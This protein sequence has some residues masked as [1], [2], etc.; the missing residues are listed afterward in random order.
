[1]SR[2]YTYFVTSA[3]GGATQGALRCRL[4]RGSEREYLVCLKKS[5]IDVYSLEKVG[6]SDAEGDER[7]EAPT[8]TATIEAHTNLLTFIEFRPPGADQSHLLA[9]T[10]NM[11]LLLLTFDA[12]A[13]K[14]ASRPLVSLQEIGAQE[15]ESDV[16]LRIDPG[17][18]FILFH[19]QKKTLK[20]VV[21][22]RE[23][24]FNIGHVITM[25][26]GESTF[27][28]VAFLDV[29][30]REVSGPAAARRADVGANM[31]ASR[32]AAASE[33]FTE[34]SR[35]KMRKSVLESKMLLIAAHR[36]GASAADDGEG[37][38]F[39]YCGVQL[40]FEIEHC[41]GDRRFT[42]YGCSPLFGESVP[43]AERFTR[44]VPLKLNAGPRCSDGALLLGSQAIGFVSF[45]DPRN[46]KLFHMDISVGEITS[47]C[48][49]EENRRYLVGDDTGALYLLDLV[50]SRTP[51]NSALKR[52]VE[53]T[54][55]SLPASKIA[56][57][58][59]CNSIVDVFAT[60]VGVYSPPSALVMIAPDLV[61]IAAVVG[62]CRTVRITGMHHGDGHASH[63]LMSA[64]ECD[65]AMRSVESRD[66]AD[67]KHRR[68]ESSEN[69]R[70][71]NLGPILDF[72][73]G[74]QR[75]QVAA[76]ILACCGYGAEGRVCS[77]TLGVGID[78]FASHTLEGVRRIFAVST[79]NGK[80]AITEVVMCCVFFN[81]TRFYK[82]ALP[83]TGHRRTS[84][85]TVI[86]PVDQPR[87]VVAPVSADSIG[88]TTNARTVLFG[89]YG[90]NR[91]VQVTSLG[92]SVVS[93]NGNDFPPQYF[94]VSDICSCAGV[95]ANPDAAAVA[96]VDAHWCDGGIFL[97]L[98]TH[99]ALVLSI[100]G[101]MRVPRWRQLSKQTSATAYV[102]GSEFKT[103]RPSGL[104]ALATWEDTEV[105]LLRDET[106]ETLHRTKV[107]C[108]YGV[109]ITALRFGIIEDK[110]FLFAALSD[111][112]LVVHKLTFGKTVGDNKSSFSS[113]CVGMTL[114]NIIKISED[115]IGLATLVVTPG[116]Q[117]GRFCRLAAS[118]IVTTGANPML[119]YANKGK[120]EYVPV[121][122]P[123]IATICSIDSGRQVGHVVP[124]LYTCNR[125][126][127]CIG[128]LDSTSQLHVETICSGRSFD[129]ICYHS[130]SDLVV[131]GCVGEL[132]ADS[133]SSISR[134]SAVQAHRSP[135]RDSEG[136]V[137][138]DGTAFRCIDVSSMIPLPGIC[139]LEPCAKFICLKTKEVVHTLKIP[140]RHVVSGVTTVAFDGHRTMIAI[141]T[142]R[143]SD[144]DEVPREGHI[145]L[146]DVVSSGP[147]SWNIVFL[148]TV[149]ALSA[150]IVEMTACSNALVVALND[151]V[152][153]MTLR[154]EDRPSVSQS[155]A[156]TAK[157]HKLEA[158]HASD[159][160]YG[161][162]ELVERAEYKSCTYVVSLD[163]YKDVIVVGD[164]MNSARMLRWRGNELRE[165][166]KD[167]NSVYCTAV[168]AIDKT[169]CVVSDSSGNFHVLGKPGS[170]TNDLEAMRVEDAGLFHHG[171]NINR[172]R[173][174]P[175][176]ENTVPKVESA[177]GRDMPTFCTTT[178]CDRRFC[179]L[180]G[181]VPV[182]TP[183]DVSDDLIRGLSRPNK[184]WNYGFKCVLTCATSAGSL[185]RLCLFE[186]DRLF[187]RL[188]LV[189]E[190][191]NR[192]QKKV[193]NISNLHWRSFKNRWSVSP[194]RAF[195]DGDV[196]ESFV[197]LDP[198]LRQQ[199]FD[200]IAEKESQ[201]MFY[202]HELL[203]LEIEHIRRLR[204]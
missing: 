78:L 62:N 65:D 60:K 158:V 162:F 179:C 192:V 50:E 37:A 163:A 5:R 3:P 112:T 171:E 160:D 24:Y 7:P 105:V 114:E 116:Q 54:D 186:D 159:D 111:G 88:L 167:F 26:T 33:S 80:S 181:D 124:L 133:E 82:I 119:I 169:H 49:V 147:D 36:R 93:A 23:N 178:Q 152:T 196:V 164:L 91:I 87:W 8:L 142:S 197:D 16:V 4:A 131:V 84:A 9:L 35:S 83:G 176:A 145:Y 43:L 189:E 27:L 151:A 194:P 177:H 96:V 183:H 6:Q 202:S 72:T 143:V 59:T 137:P 104:I 81:Y 52:R 56:N 76:P 67:H 187:Y 121:N 45:R 154:R 110:A 128:E 25:R 103:A 19:G 64:F 106:L 199:V 1:M 182:S 129:K 198:S 144:Q 51:I 95:V 12:A 34:L 123:H 134:R 89:R 32:L 66:G 174:N 200:S 173:A 141:G 46:V 48:T 94:S 31:S 166:C 20:C 10:C 118:R 130:E 47:H 2:L 153:V 175:P 28:D 69:W 190:A 113:G 157:T 57:V 122:A 168:A 117:P 115:P 191:M 41:D 63:G 126:Q 139:K 132:V 155:H 120:V 149:T 193:G 70:Q 204:R 14:F 170:A 97:L 85:R 11:L 100:E 107:I 55:S 77:I 127:L 138:R 86:D 180:Q 201:G 203:A 109:A 42:A 58:G 68:I 73:F 156:Q 18:H 188:G 184:F 39:W 146:V 165:V 38:E 53:A 40:F 44:F 79:S 108:G 90:S 99:V 98:S 101:G 185:I 71:T 15:I 148:R 135:T 21:L 13:G 30:L 195:I 136:A 172:I 140:S 161:S 125:D 61:Y 29:A 74:P 92:V 22:D 102:S 150:G 75:N 17:Y